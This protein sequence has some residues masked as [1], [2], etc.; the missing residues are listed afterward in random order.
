MVRPSGEKVTFEV[1]RASQTHTVVRVPGHG[2]PARPDG[3]RSSEGKG[4]LLVRLVV[5]TPTKLTAEQEELFR[6]LAEL[7]GTPAPG[8]AKGIFG[9]LKDRLT[10]D[11]NPKDEK[12]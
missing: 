1:P 4:D 12:K 9:K 10:G 8:P 11:G 6:R 3:R 7:E 5:E 2:M